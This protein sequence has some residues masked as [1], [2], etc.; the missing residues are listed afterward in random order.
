MI[1][2]IR[3]NCE[4]LIFLFQGVAPSANVVAVRAFNKKGNGSY[5]DVIQAIQ[6]IVE[7][8]AEY[9]IRVV[10][11]SISGKPRSHYWVQTPSILSVGV[12]LVW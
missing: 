10:N 6:W 1:L 3:L 4:I 9:D 11:L 5:G 7:H 12:Q 8:R 2:T